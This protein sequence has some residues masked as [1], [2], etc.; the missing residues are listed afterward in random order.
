MQLPAQ[1]REAGC[2]GGLVAVRLMLVEADDVGSGCGEDVLDV[3]LRCAAV[4][5]VARTVGVH[6]LGDG[7]LAAGSHGIP[8]LPGPSVLLFPDAVLDLLQRLRQQE[9]VS[10]SSG[11]VPGAFQAVFAGPA[12]GTGKEHRQPL[13]PVGECRLPGR[14]GRSVRTSQPLV[15]P[16]GADVLLVEAR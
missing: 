16:V 6:S 5:T 4:A 1:A 8:V 3:G 9:D 14:T 2:Q 15:I 7:G 13:V 11:G 12:D 10:A